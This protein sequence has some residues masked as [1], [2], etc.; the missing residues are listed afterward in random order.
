MQDGLGNIFLLKIWL[1]YCQKRC[2]IGV[3]AL[4]QTAV[5]LLHY[6][7]VHVSFPCS[8][9]GLKGNVCSRLVSLN[10]D[11]RKVKV[12]L[13][14]SAYVLSGE[15][16]FLSVCLCSGLWH[17]TFLTYGSQQTN[18]K[19]SY[20]NQNAWGSIVTDMKFGALSVDLCSRKLSDTV[21]SA[22]KF[23]HCKQTAGDSSLLLSIQT[24]CGLH[25]ASYTMG[26]RALSHCVKDQSV[27]LTAACIYCCDHECV[28][29]YLCRYILMCGA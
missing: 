24:G 1:W 27:N 4:F 16:V 18:C 2:K 12:R 3:P 26:T 28:D 6:R 29:L 22:E 25:S 11:E 14:R 15:D 13:V 19:L 7:G 8:L 10:S 9:S 20:C 23:Q 21:T 17:S 5:K